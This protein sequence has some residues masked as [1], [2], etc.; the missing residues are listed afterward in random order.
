MSEINLIKTTLLR[1]RNGNGNANVELKM[2]VPKM[3]F[4]EVE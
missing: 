4:E 1:E 3:T 2:Q